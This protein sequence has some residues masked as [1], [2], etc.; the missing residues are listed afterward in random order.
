MPA[1][2]DRRTILTIEAV[3]VEAVALGCTD[4]RDA[5]A[6]PSDVRT[7]FGDDCR[8]GYEGPKVDGHCEHSIS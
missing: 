3:A 6:A 4:Y 5:F 1:F 7:W 2:S 8:K